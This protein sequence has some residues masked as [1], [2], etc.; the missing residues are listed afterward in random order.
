MSTRHF[1]RIRVPRCQGPRAKREKETMFTASRAGGPALKDTQHFCSARPAGNRG[2]KDVL[3]KPAPKRE[4]PSANQCSS[5]Q[6]RHAD[7]GTISWH[8]VQC[9][10]FLRVC[11]CGTATVRSGPCAPRQARAPLYL[12]FHAAPVLTHRTNHNGVLRSRS[13][14]F[15]GHTLTWRAETGHVV[16]NLSPPETADNRHRVKDWAPQVGI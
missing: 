10:T 6:D 9:N 1:L 11:E 8:V 5:L 4:R 13:T 14:N 2:A 7:C 12:S 16:G 15:I 3:A